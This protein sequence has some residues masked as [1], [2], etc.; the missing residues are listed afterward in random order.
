[1]YHCKHVS[2]YFRLHINS[3][4]HTAMW[5]CCAQYISLVSC[6]LASIAMASM[7]NI[8]VLLCC[9]PLLWCNHV[10]D[11]KT[12]IHFIY[13]E[14]VAKCSCTLDKCNVICLS[15]LYT[16]Y[17]YP[18]SLLNA[19]EGFMTAVVTRCFSPMKYILKTNVWIAEG[20]QSSRKFINKHV[21]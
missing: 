19:L 15:L 17:L 14:N 16:M 11:I 12:E 7:L 10:C 4:V 8:C 9:F 18:I 21:A 3:S 2:A 6:M 1:M 5:Q 13:V 20:V